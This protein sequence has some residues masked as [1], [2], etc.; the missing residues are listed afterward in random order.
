MQEVG[1]SLLVKQFASKKIR[2]NGNASK[3]IKDS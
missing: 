3:V 1:Q 2:M